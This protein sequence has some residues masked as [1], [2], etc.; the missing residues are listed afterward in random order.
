MLK[1]LIFGLLV[2]FTSTTY[3]QV[4]TTADNTGGNGI[5]AVYIMSNEVP[6]N[7]ILIYRLN[8]NG[9]LSYSPSVNASGAGDNITNAGYD[10]NSISRSA[11]QIYSNYLFA[12][13][14]GSNRLSM[15]TINT[16]DATTLTRITTQP[17]NGS[18]PVSVAVNATYACVLSIGYNGSI[19]CFTYNSSNLTSP[20]YFDLS[21]YTNGNFPSNIWYIGSGEILFAADNLTLIVTINYFS[22]YSQSQSQILFFGFNGGLVSASNTT[23]NGSVLSV[24][25][26][27]TNGLFIITSSGVQFM[28]YY[29]SIN[30]IVN[31][32]SLPSTYF[33]V[34]YTVSY[35]TFSPTIG[36]YFAIS[37]GSGIVQ[38]NVNI[39]GTPTDP[40]GIV[41]YYTPLCGDSPEGA[42]IVTIN[43]TDYMF[44]VDSGANFIS[45]YQ[46]QVGNS[47]TAY[48]YA[49]TQA[50]SIVLSRVSGI[51]AYIQN[52]GT[53]ST[54]IRL[55][56]SYMIFVLI[57]SIHLF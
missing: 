4:Y 15:F 11:I 55:I 51:A 33:S 16:S 42:T 13:N 31:T 7:R 40:F 53:P 27:G 50:N 41:P 19:S 36:S 21:G 2:V 57:L 28:T 17:V 45:S 54:A 18:F 44:V 43:N 32:S 39:S 46:L 37:S 6:M 47:P 8:S 30:G 52:I 26:V 29:Q 14:P 23:L 9:K 24:T 49:A 35:P 5:G 56:F 48:C 22:T 12:V 1:S 25:L 38:M 34:P 20:F 3:A 10:P